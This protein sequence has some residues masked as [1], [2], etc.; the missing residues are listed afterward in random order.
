MRAMVSARYLLNL[1][2]WSLRARSFVARRCSC[3]LARSWDRDWRLR[4]RCLRNDI[5]MKGILMGT[6]NME[7]Q[8]H[9]R[10]MIGIYPSDTLARRLQVPWGL[11]SQEP[12]SVWCLGPETSNIGYLDPLGYNV[13]TIV[14]GFHVSG[15]S[16]FPVA[17][18]CPTTQRARSS[19]RKTCTFQSR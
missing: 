15:H 5:A 9:S 18:Y 14:L 8:V 7:A 12:L 10:N 1:G 13:A 11:W 19:L 17:M 3:P 2:T 16:R 6:P 4:Y